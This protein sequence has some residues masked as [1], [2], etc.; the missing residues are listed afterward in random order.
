[1]WLLWNI[2]GEALVVR[3]DADYAVEI[4]IDLDMAETVLGQAR[5]FVQWMLE[6]LARKGFMDDSLALSIYAGQ[7]ASVSRYC[8]GVQQRLAE[9][10]D[11]KSGK[12]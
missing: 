8:D 12:L 7:L 10:R 6:Y 5:R 2:Y 9:R 1:M 11:L 3:E 4:P